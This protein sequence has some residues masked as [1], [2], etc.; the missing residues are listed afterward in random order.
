MKESYKNYT[1]E[2]IQGQDPMN[3]RTDMGNAGTMACFHNRYTLGDKDHGLSIEECQAIAEN[4]DY[5]SLPLFLY[6]HSGI[7]INTSGFGCPWDSGQV[8]II[9]I[10]RCDAE[11][12]WPGTP[13]ETEAKAIDCLKSEV[14][15]YDQYLTGDV[16]G[17]VIKDALGEEVESIWGFF[18]QECCL[19]EAKSIVDYQIELEAK[20]AVANF[21]ELKNAL[22]K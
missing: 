5:I 18:G 12:D 8:G 7:T 15:T 22:A 10:P 3:P 1:I 9:Y 21:S 13:E 20:N 16:W 2:I 6:D 19:E 11:E 17:F 14:K 4:P